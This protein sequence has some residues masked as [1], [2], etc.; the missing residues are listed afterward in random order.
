MKYWVYL[1]GEVPGSYLPKDLVDLSNFTATS[2]VCPAEGEIL[3]KNW[4]RAGEFT[5]IIEALQAKENKT[6]P[7][8]DPSSIPTMSG[9]EVEKL[10]DQSSHRLFRHVT[11]LM[12]ELENRREERSLTLSLQRQIVR[13][14]EEMQAARESATL[15]EGRASKVPGLEEALRTSELK[16]NTLESSLK[17]S[18]ESLTD[19]RMKSE[20]T[21]NDLEATKRRLTESASD[22][23]I[24]NRLVDKLSHDL[25]EKELS[26]AKSLALI[27]RF[28]EE[29]GRIHPEATAGMSPEVPHL[30]TQTRHDEPAPP[31]D[32]PPAPE[33]EP[34]P[35]SGQPEAQ[36]ALG[37][38]FKK[39]IPRGDSADH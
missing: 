19:L 38:F 21:R 16:A 35:P 3:E 34:P 26:L 20:T 33:A 12:K 7:S 8:T 30:E 1:D 25:T 6:P 29:L 39:Y 18:Q 5:D 27:K 11:N 23:S 36:S 31:Q 24:R 22:L 4:L 9:G 32:D 13:L 17:I 10:I 2:L 37:K 28:E 14:K 15:S